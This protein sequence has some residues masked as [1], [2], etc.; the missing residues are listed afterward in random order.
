MKSTVTLVLPYYNQPDMLRYQLANWL[1]YEDP[2]KFEF[3]VVD[4]GSS[5][6]PLQAIQGDNYLREN[7]RKLP[8]R[9]F[10]I[11]EDIPWN[12]GEAR[13]IGWKEARAEWIFQMD[14][15]HVLGPDC[16]RSLVEWFEMQ[17]VPNPDPGDWYRFRRFR[18]GAAD[19]TRNKDAL[20]RDAKYGEIK[21]HIDS[22]LCTKGFYERAGG[23][24]LAFSG[25]L[26]GGSPF[27][28][29]MEKLRIASLAPPEIWLE[30]LTTAVIADASADLDRDTSEYKRRRATLEKAG[31][32]KGCC[33]IRHN[34]LK[35]HG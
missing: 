5:V 14:T 25:C 28:H 12:R 16:A 29:Q 8:L 6:R 26:G 2:S 30:V 27:L 18:V 35:V 22:Y 3:I 17:D 10:R 23:Y 19:H 21:P 1:S 7:L 15:D 32:I 13:N 9:I 4:D 24:N 34:Y 33:E 20:P 11:D 31:K